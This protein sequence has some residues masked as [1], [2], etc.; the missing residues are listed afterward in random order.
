[1]MDRN[2]GSA[3]MSKGARRVAALLFAAL[4]LL[5]SVGAHDPSCPHHGAVP[6][7]DGPPAAG[8]AGHAVA[9]AEDRADPATH[10]SAGAACTC[11]GACHTGNPPIAVQGAPEIARASGLPVASSPLP[12]GDPLPPP[13]AFLLPY[14]NGPPVPPLA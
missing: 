7:H 4:V 2:R 5:R 13:A 8:H 3:R 14:A 10:T 9:G 11:I 1:M 6:F 12:Q